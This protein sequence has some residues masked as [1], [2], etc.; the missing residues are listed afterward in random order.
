MADDRHDEAEWISLGGYFD[1]PKAPEGFVT[2][3]KREPHMGIVTDYRYVRPVVSQQPARK[4]D[5]FRNTF[6]ILHNI[7]MWDLE[8]AGIIRKDDES[9]WRRFND[10]LTTFV[11]KLDDARLDALYALVQARQPERYRD[12]A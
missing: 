11:L 4:V 8:N 9:K 12:A 7:A 3:V 10:D 2:E 1:P 6:A 5:A